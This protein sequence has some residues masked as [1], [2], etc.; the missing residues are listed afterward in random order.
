VPLCKAE[1]AAYDDAVRWRNPRY[2]VLLLAAGMF[3]LPALHR[4]SSPYSGQPVLSVSQSPPNFVGSKRCA[5]CH[6]Q[7]ADRW[8]KSWHSRA[9]SP[10]RAEFVAG[11]FNGDHYLGTSSEAWMTQRDG[12]YR[13]RTTDSTGQLADVRVKWVIGG[14]R[15]QDPVAVMP[16]GAWQVLPVYYHVT[17][18][19]WVDY[20]E[21]KQG[22]LTPDH[23]FFWANFRRTANHECLDCHSTG[24]STRYDRQSRMWRTEFADP[25]VACESCH[26]PGGRHSQT[27]QASDIVNPA[28]IERQR[29]M[30][31]CAQC[32]GP[33]QPLFPI[34]DDARRFRPGS[35]Y[36][37]FYQAVV[38]VDGADRAGDYFADGRPKTSSFEYQA[39]SQSRC[40]LLSKMTCLT[41]HS[42]PHGDHVA[43]DLRPEAAGDDSCRNCHAAVFEQRTDHTKHQAQAAQ[44]CLACHMPKVITGVLD[45]FADHALDVPVPENTA[46]HGVPNACAACHD[47]VRPEVLQQDLLRLWPGALRRQLRRLRLADA[48][49]E[50][51]AQRSEAALIGVITDETEAA[52]LR[53]A[54]AV[55][56]GQRFPKSASAVLVPLLRNPSPLLRA[57]ALEG[58]G[59][60]RVQQNGDAIA[61]LL[62]DPSIM[63]RQM[64]ALALANLGDS[65]AEAA[66]SRLANDKL[67]GS[68]PRPHLTLGMMLLQ[69]NQPDQAT[70][71]L[72][73][74]VDLMPYLSDALSAL[75]TAYAREGRLDLARNRAMEALHFSPQHASAQRLLKLLAGR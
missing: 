35:N 60:A 49:D 50:S 73:R 15:M 75:G 16:D 14:K 28:A 65:R 31:V 7:E 29:S 56:L 26:G 27:Q 51:T 54:S 4:E 43:N 41:C 11:K 39:L 38:V 52:M 8:S 47:K 40:F 18:N 21:A 30:S 61:L 25:A 3:F 44:S 19:E 74:A 64:A 62:D 68:L 48:I 34:L 24:L 33:R 63:V 59:F 45:Q 53:G 72:E 22:K 2:W 13:M 66:L 69:H 20:T 42:A 70:L 55:L 67:T 71:E 1:A 37:D 32:H 57:R 23:P 58:L 17:G 12:E 10:A 6:A 46:R 5:E 36:D 9:L